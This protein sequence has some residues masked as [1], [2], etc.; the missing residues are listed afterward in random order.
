MVRRNANFYEV[1]DTT[2]SFSLAKNKADGVE[3]ACSPSF[4]GT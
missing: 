2:S 1:L 3:G 4:S